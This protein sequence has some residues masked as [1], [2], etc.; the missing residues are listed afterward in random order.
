L[1]SQ[2][3]TR[4]KEKELPN[5]LIEQYQAYRA[6]IQSRNW[7]EHDD[8][9]AAVSERIDFYERIVW[10]LEGKEFW[11]AMGSR[12]KELEELWRDELCSDV[13]VNLVEQ[14]LEMAFLLARG[15]STLARTVSSE[16]KQQGAVLIKASRQLMDEISRL[17]G[18]VE[19]E[20]TIPLELTNALSDGSLLALARIQED[21][22]KWSNSVPV[23]KRPNVAGSAERYFIAGVG[24]YFK[25]FYGEHLY[26]AT[27]S[28]ACCVY[29]HGAVSEGQVRD[30][31]RKA[32]R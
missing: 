14:L 18:K 3:W 12:R 20:Y 21:A 24:E 1:Q 23:V 6:E 19:A 2:K 28:L 25:H 32:N 26:L 22:R 9:S 17:R 15:T 29:G 30:F 27:A 4:L 31:F 7:A 13:E 8:I 16:R 11:A 5:W 10:N